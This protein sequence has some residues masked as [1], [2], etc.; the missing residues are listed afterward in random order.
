MTAHATESTGFDADYYGTKY[1]DVVAVYGTEPGALARHYA[2]YGM[3]EGR[4]K[5][6]SEDSTYRAELSDQTYVDVCI[7][8]QI[9]RYYENGILVR[10]SPCVTGLPDGGRSTPKGTYEL[11]THAKGK[12][13]TGPTWHVWVDYWMR[14]TTNGACGLH[15]A[16]WRDD[17]EF[18]GETYKTNG[19]HGCVNLPH[20]FA[21]WLFDRVDVGTVVVVR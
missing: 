4:Y 21:E 17:S 15:D 10:Q 9:V 2:E 11:Q 6:A 19:S 13:L 3:R 12:Y 20:E 7:D 8:E 5:N 18:G 16:T 14:F 1:P